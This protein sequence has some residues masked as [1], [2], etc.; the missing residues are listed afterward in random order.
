[1]AHLTDIQKI[2][3][4]LQFARA[5]I[6]QQEAGIALETLSK[7]KPEIDSYAGTQEWAEFS[8]LVGEAYCAKCDEKAKTFLTEAKDK[9]ESLPNPSPELQFRL[10]LSSGNYEMSI[11]RCTHRARECYE[12]AK[13]SA[14]ELG[15]RENVAR[16]ELKIIRIDLRTDQNP[17]EENFQT[18]CR[19]AKQGEFTWEHRLAVWHLHLGKSNGAATGLRYAR[20]FSSATEEYFKDLLDSV[21][22]E[23][24]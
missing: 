12:R 18:M 6:N 5:Q 10:W 8:L 9:I 15:V 3:A 4:N 2:R 16:V 7:I 17:E 13:A 11:N 20:H 1:M 19:V 14:L 24:D 22:S 23:D 21:R